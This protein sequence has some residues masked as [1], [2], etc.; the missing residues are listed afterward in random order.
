MAKKKTEDKEL[1]TAA[2]LDKETVKK[3]VKST[4][5]NTAKVSIKF[6]GA[7]Y[8]VGH[9]VATVLIKNGKAKLA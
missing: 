7:V 3:E 8:I 5:P 2:P 9:Q 6:K 1:K 4:I